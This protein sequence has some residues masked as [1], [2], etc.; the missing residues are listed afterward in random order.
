MKIELTNETNYLDNGTYTAT[1]QNVF[2]FPK[3]DDTS[4][5]IEF[6][7]ND[8]EHTV[9]TKFYNDPVKRLGSYPWNTVFKA[10]NSDDTA[11]LIGRKVKFEIKNNT[12][13][14]LTYTNIKKITLI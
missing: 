7:L 9:F 6:A 10:L 5:G 14:D 12:K 11:D 8:A 3:G 1:I 13:N 2:E 4:I